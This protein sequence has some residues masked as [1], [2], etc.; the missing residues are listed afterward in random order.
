[1]AGAKRAGGEKDRLKIKETKGSFLH[2][3]ENN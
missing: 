2:R 1:M 3:H